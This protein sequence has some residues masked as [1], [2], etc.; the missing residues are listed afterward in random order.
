MNSF[1]VWCQCRSA[2]ELRWGEI[3]EVQGWNCGPHCLQLR[4]LILGRGS[5]ESNRGRIQIKR[6]MRLDTPHRTPVGKPGMGNCL[7]GA[8]GA[9]ARSIPIDA[10]GAT[11]QAV[12]QV[13][14]AGRCRGMVEDEVTRF[15]Q[16]KDTGPTLFFDPPGNDGG[17]P[18]SGRSGSTGGERIPEFFES[19]VVEVLH[20]VWRI[21][22]ASWKAASRSG[23]GVRPFQPSVAEAGGFQGVPG[24]RGFVS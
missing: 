4:K 15:G 11:L 6:N 12:W 17:I 7:R 18:W 14:G 21:G 5:T 1:C 19:A 9:F 16:G 8:C 20:G 13:S 3:S 2:R 22:S 24:G 10:H 23:S